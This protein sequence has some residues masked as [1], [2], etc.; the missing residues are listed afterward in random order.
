MLRTLMEMCI[1]NQFHDV[2]IA[3]EELQVMMFMRYSA[4]GEFYSSEATV[5]PNDWNFK[6]IRFRPYRLRV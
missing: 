3:E 6:Y 2:R 5:L 1:T 4:S